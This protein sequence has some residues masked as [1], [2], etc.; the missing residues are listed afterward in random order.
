MKQSNAFPFKIYAHDNGH[1]VTS[2]AL[3][4]SVWANHPKKKTWYAADFRVLSPTAIQLFVYDMHDSLHGGI[5]KEIFNEVIT[6]LTENEQK[7]LDELVLSRYTDMA[8]TELCRREDA[9]RKKK[10]MKIRKE[11]F[12]K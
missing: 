6:E 10:I 11:L 7:M 12:D 4:K 2:P 9:A 3:A 1:F 8:E 5:G